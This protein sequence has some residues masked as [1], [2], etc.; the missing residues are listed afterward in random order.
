M[1]RKS[2]SNADQMFWVTGQGSETQNEWHW[3][4]SCSE[5]LSVS[6]SIS[7]LLINISDKATESDCYGGGNLCLL[8]AHRIKVLSIFIPPLP[9]NAFILNLRCTLTF[10]QPNSAHPS[11]LAFSHCFVLHPSTHLVPLQAFINECVYREGEKMGTKGEVSGA[12]FN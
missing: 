12:Y 9:F 2:S 6:Q 3:V 7:C 11:S 8:V 5:T 4:P 10:S 1:D